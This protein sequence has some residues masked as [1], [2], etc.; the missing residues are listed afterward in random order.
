MKFLL[1]AEISISTMGYF[2]FVFVVFGLFIRIVWIGSIWEGEVFV[3][4]EF[5]VFVR[6]YGSFVVSLR[7]GGNLCG[8]RK[9]SGLHVFG[10]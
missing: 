3:F 2:L 10:V 6:N 1:R 4:G 8:K 7:L 9:E 5:E